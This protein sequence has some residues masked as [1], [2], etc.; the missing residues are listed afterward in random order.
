MALK[1]H[2]LRAD[3]WLDHDDWERQVQRP[4]AHSVP[5]DVGLVHLVGYDDVRFELRTAAGGP[6][7]RGRGS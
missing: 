6:R 2:E 7:A 3:G 4:V 5:L 1:R